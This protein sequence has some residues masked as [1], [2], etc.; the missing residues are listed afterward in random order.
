MRVGK[1]KRFE[2]ME[3]W[4]LA[5]NLVR[6]I[7]SASGDSLFFRDFGLREQIRRASIRIV[8]NIA[9]GFESRISNL[10]STLTGKGGGLKLLS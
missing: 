3:V 6:N 7:Y 5:R 1:I 4:R 8:S 10:E 9:E 2:E